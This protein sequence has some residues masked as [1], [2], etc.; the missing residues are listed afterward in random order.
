MASIVEKISTNIS[1]NA[2]D[3]LSLNP[4][5]QELI[6]IQCGKPKGTRYHPMFLRWA[7]SVYSRGGNTAYDSLK[8]IMR[9]P[10]VSTLKSYINEYEQNLALEN[11]WGHGRIGFF[12]H[13]SFKIQK[14]LLWSQRSNSYVGYLDFEDEAQDLKSFAINCEKELNAMGSNTIS[15]DHISEKYEH[16]LATQ[17]HQIVWHS[18][19]HNF[20]FPLSYY[21]V[22]T[23]STHDLNTLLFGLAA[24]LECIGIH[25]CG[26]VCNGASEN[27]NHI[28]SFDWFASTWSVG[29]IVEVVIEK[30]NSYSAKIL[31]ANIDHTKFI[32]QKLDQEFTEGITIDW[33][34]LR[35]VIGSQ[36]SINENRDPWFF[37]SDP[38]H[39]FKKLRNNLS[40]SHTGQGSEKN[41]CEIMFDGKEVSWKHIKGVYDYTSCHATAK[42]TR[43]TKHHIWLTSWSK[44]CVDLAEQT[45]SKDVENALEAI[46][47]LK[48]ISE[49]T[50]DMLEGLFGTIHELSGDSSTQTLQGY[51]H[52]LNKYQITALESS[53]VKSFNYGNANNV[54]SGMHFLSRR[55]YQKQMS[56]ESNPAL[57]SL[58]LHSSRLVTLSLLSQKI[59]ETLLQD[60]LLMGRIA[61]LSN[62]LNEY[63]NN[64]NLSILNSNVK[65]YE[66]IEFLIYHNSVDVL[67]QNW[68]NEVRLIAQSAIPKKRGV[69]WM[70]RWSSNLEN[71]LNNYLCSGTW[72]VYFQQEF[73]LSQFSLSVQRIVAFSMLQKVILE[74]FKG[75]GTKNVEFEKGADPNLLPQVIVN[76]DPAEASKFAYIVGWVL[77]KLTK[78]DKVMMSHP[79]FGIMCSLLKNLCSEN[80]EYVHEIHSQTTNIIPGPEI[81]DF[82]YHFE[83]IIIQLFEK[84][85]E[86]GPNILHYIRISLLN[87]L[88]LHEKFSSLLKFAI[89][90]NISSE[91]FECKL[92]LSNEDLIFLFEKLVSTYM[93]SWQKT[94]RQHNGYIPEKG[95]ASLRENL[96]VMRSNNQNLSNNE[97]GKISNQIKKAN[98]PTDP[99]LAIVQLRVWVHL[100][101]VENQFA[102]NFLVTDLLWLLWAFGVKTSQKRKNTLVPLLISHLK[103]ETPFSEEALAKKNIFALE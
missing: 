80:V 35:P 49:G 32:V 22:N 15:P 44:M 10:S 18:I 71:H 56:N 100:E 94:W 47:E 87:N 60:D 51:G 8:G 52:A 30:G 20:S 1:N 53:E 76:L 84:H 81:M 65:W 24:K 3:I 26:S 43:L 72:F 83:S 88:H 101:D 39:V 82:M 93:K 63:I 96:K 73:Q 5:F 9:L 64:E 38:I 67:L 79:K 21:G 40:K 95:T 19:T 46:E 6:C 89:Q 7:I 69:K 29:D 68:Q 23:L 66:L 27:R 16:G 12:S 92:I 34:F 36:L 25:T 99:M 33:K 57:V 54:G 14:G 13:D 97:K 31:N 78:D 77:F 103:S 75:N 37:I 70:L 59:F 74:T 48:D 41:V 62:S 85:H 98:L 17:V 50:R 90:D 42:A 2:T 28:K 45:L 11:V 102:K 91:N 58:N 4:I 61:P 86:L 55:D